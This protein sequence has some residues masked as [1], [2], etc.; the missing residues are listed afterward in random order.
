MA[1]CGETIS[2]IPVQ[3]RRQSLG[4]RSGAVMFG[5]QTPQ[6]DFRQAEQASRDQ[7]ARLE[8]IASRRAQLGIQRPK[9]RES[10]RHWYRW[11]TRRKPAER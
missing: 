6:Q 3:W 9:L 2:A 4:R 11:L 1:P 5:S 8:G 7:Y 10:I